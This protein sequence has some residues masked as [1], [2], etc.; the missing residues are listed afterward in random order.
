M[1]GLIYS[2]RRVRLYVSVVRLRPLQGLGAC[3]NGWFFLLVLSAGF[4]SEDWHHISIVLFLFFKLVIR[5]SIILRGRWVQ[6]SWVWDEIIYKKHIQLSHSSTTQV[7]P[8]LLA[9]DLCRIILFLCQMES[10]LLYLMKWAVSRHYTSIM[11]SYR[12]SLGVYVLP[13]LTPIQT[14]HRSLIRR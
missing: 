10:D 1:I 5:K 6:I 4:F 14:S 2:Y 3:G 7:T 11:R 9:S 8:T 13:A 12:P